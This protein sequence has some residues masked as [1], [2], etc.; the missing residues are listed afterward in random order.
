MCAIPLKDTPNAQFL[1]LF[2]R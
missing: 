2:D 1:I